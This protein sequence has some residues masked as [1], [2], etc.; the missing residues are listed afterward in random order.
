ME[1]RCGVRSIGLIAPSS[2]QCHLSPAGRV[3]LGSPKVSGWA[4][5]L[6]GPGWARA[7]TSRVVSTE[8]PQKKLLRQEVVAAHSDGDS[9]TAKPAKEHRVQARRHLDG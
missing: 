3:W 7:E 2:C 6:A 4:R 5:P 1:V 9:A 8:P